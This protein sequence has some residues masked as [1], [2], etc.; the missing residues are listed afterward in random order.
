MIDAFRG[1]WPQMGDAPLHSWEIRG[2]HANFKWLGVGIDTFDR[3]VSDLEGL[4]FELP[5]MGLGCVIDRPGYNARYREKYGR[6]RWA[7]C[8][9]AFAVAVERATKYAILRDRKLR[10]YV[11][12]TDKK[13]D[14]RMNDYYH[15]LRGDGHWF[16]PGTAGKYDPISSKEYQATLYEFR[17][18][19]KTSKLMQIADLYLWPICMGGY[20]K[21]N[22]AYSRLLAAGKLIDCH[23]ATEKVGTQGI[24]YSCFD[25]GNS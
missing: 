2:R 23:L 22:F 12:R 10:I 14:R 5:V 25:G 8:K 9:T 11:E 18:K 6:Q 24:K 15:T 20:E 7:L 3:F 1:R 21:S 4:L 17:T 13:E 19:A 16:D